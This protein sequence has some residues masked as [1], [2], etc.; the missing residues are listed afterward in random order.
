MKAR[1]STARNGY[2]KNREHCSEL[3]SLK[4]CKYREVHSRVTDDKTNSRTQN[5]TYK[6]NGCHIITRLFHKPNRHNSRNKNVSE[7]HITP[8]V[9]A[10]SDGAFNT[11][12]KR[13]DDKDNTD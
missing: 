2:E 9:L 12:C 11:D 10:E 6:H 4:T 8:A 7:Y 1:Y 3:L 5:H 13:S